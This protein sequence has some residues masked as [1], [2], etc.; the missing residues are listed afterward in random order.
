VAE[1]LLKAMHDNHADFTNTFRG[2]S[3]AAAGTATPP[4]RN[5]FADP[6]AFDA[7]LLRWQHRLTQEAVAPDERRASMRLA[8]LAYIPRNHRIEAVIRAAVDG[9]D[10][11][12]FHEL[13]EVLAKPFDDQPGRARYA[14]PP[15]SGERVLQTFCGT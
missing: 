1:D 7:W 15:T 13:V 4:V 6:S 9:D 5:L 2:L 11:G 3:D 10:F 12:P 8:N 14:E